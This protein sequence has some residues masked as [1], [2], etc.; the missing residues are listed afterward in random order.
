MD[1]K[2]FELPLESYGPL[3]LAAAGGV[4]AYLA[5]RQRSRRPGGARPIERKQP[6]Q[7]RAAEAPAA[8]EPS[9]MFGPR[10]KVDEASWESF[11]ASDPPA[12]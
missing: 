5:S 11:P 12:W 2:R 3:L 1:R 9:L 10:D 7:G 4:L 8:P 6:N